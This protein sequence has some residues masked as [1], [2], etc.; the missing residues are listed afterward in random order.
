MEV[1]SNYDTEVKALV[2]MMNHLQHNCLGIRSCII[3]TDSTTLVNNFLKFKRGVYWDTHLQE[4][5]NNIFVHKVTLLYIPRHL[6]VLA[7]Q[8]SKDGSPKMELAG[9]K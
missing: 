3:L 6:N 5:H 9:G 2:I 8:F 7:D 1:R 4:L